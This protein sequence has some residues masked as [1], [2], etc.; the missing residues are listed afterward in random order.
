MRIR[1]PWL[2]PLAAAAL[3]LAFR[4]LFRTLRIQID[5]DSPWREGYHPQP[6]DRFLYC[7][8]HD[9]LLIPIFAGRPH[10]MSTLVSRH[11]DGS[12]LAEAMRRVGI[13]AVRGSSSRGGV[14]ALRQLVDVARTHH[15]TI[16]PDG[17]R[18]P[19]REVKEGIVFLASHTGRAIVPVAAACRSCWRFR[20]SWTDLMIPRP[21]TTVYGVTGRPLHV[22]PKLSREQLAQY[23][24]LLQ[25][26][27]DRANIEAEM[28]AHG[29][30][31]RASAPAA[32]Q[33]AA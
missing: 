20:G 14:Q 10:H 15:I 18:G 31:P 21:F 22:P 11:Q 7:V 26:E 17:P 19:R 4:L 28:R 16:T 25:E 24:A 2:T 9:S 32:E 29:R 1:H 6:R 5:A 12:Y 33:R 3:V 13:E 23:T 27:M 8:W 30:H